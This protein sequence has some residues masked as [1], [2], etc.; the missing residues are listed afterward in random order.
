MR[1]QISKVEKLNNLLVSWPPTCSSKVLGCVLQASRLYIGLSC[2]LHS[3]SPSLLARF[4]R[5]HFHLVSSGFTWH[6]PGAPEQQTASFFRN[7]KNGAVKKPD[8]ANG[9]SSNSPSSLNDHTDLLQLHAV[10]CQLSGG[11]KGLC[12]D[13]SYKPLPP[14]QRATNLCGQSVQVLAPCL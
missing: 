7:C 14:R 11:T 3:C 8:G 6:Q 10:D 4:L 9:S 2:W 13:S 5:S 12:L 1:P